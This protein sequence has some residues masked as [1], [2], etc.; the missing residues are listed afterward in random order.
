MRE[1]CKYKSNNTNLHGLK[2]CR[3]EIPN[4]DK[5]KFFLRGREDFLKPVPLEREFALPVI[6]NFK[7]DKRLFK[8]N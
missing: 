3:C 7:R 8:G 2:E 6:Y 4:G 1:L 5:N